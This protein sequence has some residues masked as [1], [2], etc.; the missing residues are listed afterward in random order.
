MNCDLLLYW[1][2]HTGEGSWP[3]F[4]KAVAELAGTDVDETKLSRNLRVNLSDLG[5]AD[6][7]VDGTNRWKVLPPTL[8]GIANRPEAAVLFGARTPDLVSSLKSAAGQMRCSVNAHESTM[9]PTR[10]IVEGS[11]ENIASVAKSV[12]IFFANRAADHLSSSLEAVPLQLEAA[13][14]EAPP[15]KWEVRS[16][17]LQSKA[18][19]KGLLPRSA[20]EF[21]SSYRTKKYCVHKH[22]SKLIR[23]SKREAVYASAMMQSIPLVA[24]D[25]KDLLLSTPATAPLPETY[26]RLACMCSGMPAE[27]K[28]GRRIYREVP[29]DIASLI[30]VA[31]GQRFPWFYPAEGN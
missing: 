18:W 30:S 9:Y 20:C 13:P 10:I 21:T 19:V 14:E 17:D 5:Y 25:S 22:H 3:T 16:F 24:Y 26:T 12:D 28:E 2:T 31:A 7:F 6:F 23:M 29:A 4:K 27:W 11:A 15:V 8:G 1:M